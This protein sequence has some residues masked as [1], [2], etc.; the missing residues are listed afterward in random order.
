MQAEDLSFILR[1]PVKIQAKEHTPL[2]TAPG[3]LAG[4]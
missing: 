3:R 4:P 2:I 1:T